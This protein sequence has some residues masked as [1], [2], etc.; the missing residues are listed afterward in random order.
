MTKVL[1][2]GSRDWHR[3]DLVR[4]KLRQL[5][6][7]T[8]VIHGGARGADRMAGTIADAY[9]FDVQ[10]YPAE[11]SRYGRA[12]GPVRNRLM[13]EQKPDLVIAFQKNRSAGTQHMI[14]IALRA[15]V[16]VDVVTGL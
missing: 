13:L 15:G 10:V 14:D 4:E 1:V 6:R 7:G 9:G 11:W 3:A 2:C 5:P 16:Q 12:A 8:T